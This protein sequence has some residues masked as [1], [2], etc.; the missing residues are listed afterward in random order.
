MGISGREKF[1]THRARW[2]SKVRSLESEINGDVIVISPRIIRKEYR[3]VCHEMDLLRQKGRG[4]PLPDDSD[5]YCRLA[6]VKKT[7]EWVHP[8]LIKT[9]AKGSDRFN[10]LLGHR[11]YALGPTHAVLHP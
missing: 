5:V 9:A 7:L 6:V 2:F 11:H 4:T 3:K 8:L 10:E 1:R